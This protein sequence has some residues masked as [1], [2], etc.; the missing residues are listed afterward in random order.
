M[1]YLKYFENINNL[2]FR[3]T[4]ITTLKDLNIPKYIEGNFDCSHNKLSTLE[5]CTL[6]ECNSFFCNHNKLTS[7]EFCPEI[8]NTHFWCH[9]NQL[10]SLE[11]C[12]EY[13]NGL[14]NCSYNNWTNPISYELIKKHNISFI[15][16]YNKEQLEK[17]GTYEYQKEF[18]TNTPEKYKD[19]IHIGFNKKIKD[20]FDWLFNAIDMGLM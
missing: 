12:P 16:L 6:I 1:K 5:G 3:G 4:H 18:L 10:T 9:D 2:D 20:E 11:F 14:F 7:L 15:N 19:L 13:V 8:V 17:F